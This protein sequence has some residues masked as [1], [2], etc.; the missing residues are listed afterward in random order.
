M[1][2]ANSLKAQII[3]EIYDVIL[4]PERYDNFMDLWEKH[5]NGI[6]K[7]LDPEQLNKYSIS[8]HVDEPELEAHFQRAYQILEKMGREST[9]SDS[10]K[11]YGE[12]KSEATFFINQNGRI[13]EKNKA[14][15]LLIDN[16][17][18]LEKLEPLIDIN[19]CKKLKSL[20]LCINHPNIEEQAHV[21]RFNSSK[22]T[23]K[24]ESK[25]QNEQ[26]YIARV[27]QFSH[28]QPVLL[29]VSNMAMD[30]NRKLEQLLTD[31][32]LFSPSELHIGH[33]LCL[34][35]SLQQIA[36]IRKRSL[37]TVRVQVKNMLQKTATHTQT[38]IVRL[39]V[40][41]ASFGSVKNI[42][43]AHYFVDA[44]DKQNLM[45]EVNNGREM[46]VHLFG[47][48][49][50]RPVIYVHGMLSGININSD[51]GELLA[52]NNIRLIAPIRPYYASSPPAYKVKSSP[53]EF[54]IDLRYILDYLEVE[55]API[56]G[57][58]AGSIYAFASASAMPNR[59]TGIL[60][61]SGCVPIVSLRQIIAMSPRQ[62][63]V[64]WTSRFA[65][66]LL[67]AILRT[68]ISLIDSGDEDKF[69][70]GLYGKN[71]HDRMI[72]QNKK[73]HSTIY[74]GFLFAISQGHYAFEVDAHHATRDWSKFVKKAKQKTLLIHGAFDRVTP[75][76]TVREFADLYD[77]VELIE[78]DDAGQLVFYQK[79]DAIISSLNVL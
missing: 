79:P 23:G 71:T 46:P 56:I 30:W 9:I 32:F 2:K 45:I 64:A 1:A 76:S 42:H 12:Q 75:I 10:A 41:M 66:K 15:M 70:D 31:A 14:A 37:H 40:T 38:D 35:N 77:H 63:V 36:Q 7:N 19:D 33:L 44:K 26:Y 24:A 62:R 57:N 65:P 16:I 17:D 49:N 25:Q 22:N 47:P 78:H 61:I 43:A 18:R 51:F 21:F 67:S 48:K 13:I 29:C 50:G 72:L 27:M 34:G 59:I 74:S 20:L 73:I 55:S 58:M 53:E 60:N 68:S 3:N 11:Y 6:I 52:Q 39:M 54:A 28:Q 69:L 5:I 8:K 4:Q